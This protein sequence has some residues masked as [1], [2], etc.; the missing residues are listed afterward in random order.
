MPQSS[1][2]EFRHT[3]RSARRGL[4]RKIVKAVCSGDLGGAC[5]EKVFLQEYVSGDKYGSFH[6][7]F[8][9][10]SAQGLFYLAL[11]GD[12]RQR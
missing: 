3:S 4:N 8:A 7:G 6:G 5:H 1:L 12:M 11:L 10:R 9:A 2:G